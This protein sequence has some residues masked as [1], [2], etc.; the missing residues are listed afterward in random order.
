MAIDTDLPAFIKF[1]DDTCYYK[2]DG[3]CIY[4]IPEDYFTD[5][6]NPIAM[7]VGQYVSTLGIF[8]W[9]LV[10]TN[11][12]ISE[13]KPFRYPTIIL[14]KP[15][16]IEKQKDVSLAGTKPTNYRVLHFKEGDELISDV[17]TP[18]IIDNVLAML[19]MAIVNGN[20]LPPTLPYD[21]I[22]EYFPECMELNGSSYGVN[23][24]LFGIMV[25]ESYRDPD[26]ITKPY[27]LSKA[28]N[29]SMT[30]Y[31]QVSIKT[32]PK[33]QSPY[34]SLVSENFDES[35]IASIIQSDLPEDEIPTTPLEQVMMA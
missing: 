35:L 16:Y 12:K 30:D 8:D 25:S 5:T 29:K 32:I 31:V 17:N 9:A 19:R 6:K 15:S 27:R 24:Q 3:E 2:G 14:C 22:H 11:G 21:K 7:I 33:F 28:I 13:A 1:K 23:M 20:K 26:D 4:Y 34:N 18:E 10:S